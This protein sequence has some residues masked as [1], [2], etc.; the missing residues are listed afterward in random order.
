MLNSTETTCIGAAFDLFSSRVVMWK[1]ISL[2]FGT[3]PKGTSISHLYNVIT[4]IFWSVL[5]LWTYVHRTKVT[6]KPFGAGFLILYI[7]IMFVPMEQVTI[8]NWFFFFILRHV[9]PH[10]IQI[11]S[12]LFDITWHTYH[13]LIYDVILQTL[14]ISGLHLRHTKTH[15]HNIH[16]AS[17]HSITPHVRVPCFVAVYGS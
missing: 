12:H 16:I 4:S 7:V 11:A 17:Q 9:M 6:Y 15:L 14:F 8:I 1:F 5:S 2:K 3:S 10:H 13:T